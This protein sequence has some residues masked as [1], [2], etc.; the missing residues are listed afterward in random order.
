MQEDLITPAGDDIARTEAIIDGIALTRR[1]M[2]SLHAEEA[3]LLAAAA[4][5]AREQAARGDRTHPSSDIPLRS[6]AAQIAAATR[7]SDRGVQARIGRAWQLTA[8]FPATLR[9]LET[10]EV[11]PAHANV[12]VEAGMMIADPAV[13]AAYEEAALEVAR[14]E[15]PG[16]L[17]PIV[18]MLAQRLHPVP[19]DDRHREARA[20]RRVAL[21]DGDDGM[22]E[23][24]AVLPAT[25]AHAILDRLTH[26]ARSVID[27]RTASTGGEALFDD[28][29]LL[30]ADHAAADTR[31]LDEVRA[32]ALAD[33]LLTGHS[34]RE[35][36]NRSIP[37]SHAIR[38]HV[39]ITVPLATLAGETDEPAELAGHGP[40]APATARRLAGLAS[41]WTRVQLDPVT[42]CVVAVD[43]YR[44]TAELRRLLEVRDEHCRFPGCRQPATRCDLD[45]TIAREHD[46]PTQ[47]GNLAHLCR[48]HHV[49]KHHSAWR[50]RQRP[51][52]VLEWTSPT[53]RVYP[54]TPARTVAF[55]PEPDPPPF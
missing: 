49:L 4:D 45:H 42:Q 17:R 37:Q 53:G 1:R 29:T 40:I 32:D 5:L 52:G 55:A 7:A 8:D 20:A 31:S 6:L 11:D 54:D 35:A 48:R 22:A 16:R 15:A 25:L 34:S 51:G 19:L 39:Q 44:P 30:D 13:R 47:L 18:R 9:A 24:I 10:G 33:L 2:A 12:I 38:A 23:L 36:S 21:R 27:A 26:I 50:V 3:R 46:G 14:R 41:T 43:K 28:E